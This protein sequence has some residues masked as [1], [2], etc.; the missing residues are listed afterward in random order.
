VCV[1]KGA[2]LHGFVEFLWWWPWFLVNFV[3]WWLLR[4]FAG[5]EL[6]AMEVSVMER[7]F[8]VRLRERETYGT[9]GERELRMKKIADLDSGGFSHG[10]LSD[11]RETKIE[12]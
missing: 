9:G 8:F 2:K 6:L 1:I 5:L 11:G 10:G 4:G 12:R 3:W 7:G